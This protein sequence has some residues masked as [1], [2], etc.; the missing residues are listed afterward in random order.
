MSQVISFGPINWAVVTYKPSPL[1]NSSQA[2][3]PSPPPAVSKLYRGRNTD[4]SLHCFLPFGYKEVSMHASFRNSESSPCSMT[5]AVNSG[6]TSGQVDTGLL[7]SSPVSPRSPSWP[8]WPS[9]PGKPILPTIPEDPGAPGGPGGPW[10]PGR[11][12]TS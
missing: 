6:W 4:L 3:P 2:C 1:N 10:G 8:S 9:L 5:D 12:Q 7:P 11:L